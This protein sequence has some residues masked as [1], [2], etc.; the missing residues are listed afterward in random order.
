[1]FTEAT[2]ILYKIEFKIFSFVWRQKCEPGTLEERETHIM[3]V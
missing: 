1:M 2:E 3:F